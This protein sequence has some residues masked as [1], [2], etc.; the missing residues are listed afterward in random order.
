[1]QLN[2]FI[3]DYLTKIRFVQMIQTAL[4][5]H[6]EGLALRNESDL[7]NLDEYISI[8]REY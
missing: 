6:M 3:E 7:I 4:V 5:F 1:L 2:K 8:T